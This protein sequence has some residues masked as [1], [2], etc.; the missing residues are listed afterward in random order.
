[1]LVI[2]CY[3][4]RAI[5]RPFS[6]TL[7]VRARAYRATKVTGVGISLSNLM[8]GHD[9]AVNISRYTVKRWVILIYRLTYAMEDI[10]LSYFIHENTL[11]L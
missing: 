5:P 8:E 2:Q 7:Q 10:K 3:T 6:N 11:I 9:V 4:N 1:M